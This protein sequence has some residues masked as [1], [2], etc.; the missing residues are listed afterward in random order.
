MPRGLTLLVALALAAEVRADALDFGRAS[1]VI[2]GVL[3][4][5]DPDLEDFDKE[6]RKDEA[7]AALL[8]KRGVPESRLRLLLDGKATRRAFLEAVEAAGR[9]TPR[10]GWLIV[11]FAGHGIQLDDGRVA[12]ALSDARDATIASSGL[13]LDELR[14]RIQRTL[15]CTGA[16]CPRDRARRVLLLGDACY[17]GGLGDVAERLAANGIPS[18]A[19]TSSEA[20]ND[21]TIN[22]TYTQALL[23]ALSGSA[24]ADTDRDGRITLS[25]ASQEVRASLLYREH[26]RWGFKAVR[27]SEELE[28]ARV[29]RPLGR[30]RMP[31]GYT[32]GGYA[33]VGDEVVRLVGMSGRQVVVSYFDYSERSDEKVSPRR[34]RPIRFE[35]FPVGSKLRVVWEDECWDAVVDRVDGPFHFV[36]YP[37][38]DHSW[39]EWVTDDRVISGRERCPKAPKTR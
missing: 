17:S 16:R 28:L 31:R 27:V 3:E 2:A 33:S 21:S 6:G 25:E 26:Q 15:G 34:L 13:L 1:A 18:V 9:A 5:A 10:G 32:L 29:E 24:L 19:L 30:A 36:S 12:L 38:W 22:W 39:D 23:E 37:E 4:W 35:T 7:L 20:S 11:Y 8:L 14:D